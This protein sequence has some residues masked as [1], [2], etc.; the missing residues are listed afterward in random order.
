MTSTR[1]PSTP[2]TDDAA[3]GM[4]DFRILAYRDSVVESHP[5]AEGATEWK[6]GRAANC[7]IRLSDPAVSRVHALL[8]R[9][10]D[11]FH[12]EDLGGANPILQNGQR[13]TR[14]TLVPEM[15]LVVGGTILYLDRVAK[16]ADIRI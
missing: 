5:L 4:T 10:Q 2:G 13:V 16:N 15:P 12:F 9:E 3:K 8:R 6:I 11:Q 7:D 1:F 14:G